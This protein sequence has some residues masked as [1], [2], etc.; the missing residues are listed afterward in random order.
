MGENEKIF[1]NH[2]K[3]TCKEYGIKC[4]LRNTKYVVV[5]PKQRGSGYF[6]EEGKVL[7]VAMNKPGSLGILVHEY[8]HLTQYIDQCDAWVNGIASYVKMND[9]LNGVDNSNIDSHIALARNLELD[10]EK[11]SV[12]IIK[13]FNLPIDIKEYTKKANAYVQFYNYM[14]IT[15]RWSDP[16]NSPYNNKRIIEAMPDRFNMDYTVLP[17]KLLKIFIEE[18]I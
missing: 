2:V 12:K 6:D 11:R 8:A 16:K 14:M 7:V 5:G 1:I 10:N 9:W 3:A 15:R 13:K 17:K 4:D 18:Q